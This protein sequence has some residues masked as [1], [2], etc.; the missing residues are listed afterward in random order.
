MLIDGLSITK[1]KDRLK[2]MDSMIQMLKS[3]E[4][5]NKP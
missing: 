1:S 3:I 5:I 2:H 4:F